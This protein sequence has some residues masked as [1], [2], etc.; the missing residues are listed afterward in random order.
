MGENPEHVFHT[1]AIGVSNIL[2][3]TPL[4]KEELEAQI[5]FKFLPGTVLCTMHTA[6]LDP[7]SPIE[8]LYE[9]LKAI[10]QMPSLRVLFTH[11][12]NDTDTAQL[13]EAL[14]R[15]AESNSQNSEVIPSL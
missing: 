5:G 3:T 1:G 8:Q 7:R 6:T 4:G 2:K 13:I 11:A 15:F 10:D 14:R 9:L 12:N